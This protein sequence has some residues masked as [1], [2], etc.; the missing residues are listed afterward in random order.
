MHC[1]TESRLFGAD[2]SILDHLSQSH[3]VDIDAG[4][5]FSGCRTHGLD[6]R[7]DESR[8]HIRGLQHLYN[9]LVKAVD[10]GGRHLCR[11]Q[12]PEYGFGFVAR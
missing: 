2:A 7:R 4:G 10:N 5:E 11:R 9:L 6:T 3:H 1:G 8:P 12:Q